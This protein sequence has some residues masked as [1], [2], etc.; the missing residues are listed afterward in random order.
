MSY[1]KRLSLKKNKPNLKVFNDICFE[2]IE[3]IL[4]DIENFTPIT[5]GSG[6][7]INGYFAEDNIDQLI[8]ENPNLTFLDLG[9][10]SPILKSAYNLPL[11]TKLFILAIDIHDFSGNSSINKFDYEIYLNNGSQL[12]D[13]SPCYGLKLSVSSSIKDTE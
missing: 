7:T 6:I 13:L 8:K 12:K 9:H 4:E 2:G 3:K 5:L 11:D 10:C 1:Y